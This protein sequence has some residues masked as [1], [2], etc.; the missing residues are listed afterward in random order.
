MRELLINAGVVVIG[1]SGKMGSGKTTLCETLRDHCILY[2]PNT[3]VHL[4]NFGDALKEQ[5]AAHFGFPLEWCYSQ[6]GKRKVIQSVDKSVG[7]LLQQWGTAL[8]QGVHD[9]V[10]L[11]AIDTWLRKTLA[12]LEQAK[13]DKHERKEHIV[14]IGDVRFPNEFEYI[15]SHCGGF[16]V[17]LDGDPA[18]ERARSNRD[19]EHISETA[20]DDAELF[21]FD[22]R[23]CSDRTA[24]SQAI[25]PVLRE[26]NIWK[27]QILKHA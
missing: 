4:R 7:A 8:R 5:L 26:L 24:P 21:S 17:R 23:I 9:S 25:V 11:I 15:R 20:L 16:L 19:T 6:E 2:Q 22:V 14:L 13:P 3:A 18:G 10:W 1:V 27:H 12:E